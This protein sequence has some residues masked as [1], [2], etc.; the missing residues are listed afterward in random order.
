MKQIFTCICFLLVTVGY[1]QKVDKTKSSDVFSFATFE[2]DGRDSVIKCQVIERY[3]KLSMYINNLVLNEIRDHEVKYSTRIAISKLLESSESSGEKFGFEDYS[4]EGKSNMYYTNENYIDKLIELKNTL[5]AY[6]KKFLANNCFKLEGTPPN[7]LIDSIY[8]TPVAKGKFNFLESTKKSYR[9]TS[10]VRSQDS[11]IIAFS[12]IDA[13]KTIRVRIMKTLKSNIDYKEYIVDYK[14]T[15]EQ[16]KKIR[17]KEDSITLD[18]IKTLKTKLTEL[19]QEFATYEIRFIHIS[20]DLIPSLKD[21]IKDYR[22]QQNDCTCTEVVLEDNDGDGYDSYV[23]CDDNNPNVNPGARINCDNGIDDDNCDGVKDLCC[24]DKDGDGYYRKE[25][26]DCITYSEALVST[27]EA[28]LCDCNDDDPTVHPHALINCN[29][30]YF[31]DNCDGVRDTIYKG[32]EVYLTFIDNVY[33][34]Y[35]ITAFGKDKPFYIYSGL[36]LGGI[37]TTAYFKIRSNKFYNRH[38]NSETF[39]GAKTNYKEANDLHHA[40]IISAA[41]TGAVYLTSLVDLKIRYAKYNKIRD[42]ILNKNKSCVYNYD[43]LLDPLCINSSGFGPS[44]TLKF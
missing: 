38:L 14:K 21:K 44:L 2:F 25:D 7:V 23:D 17:Y 26:C 4:L 22:N 5:D 20:E 42:G 8:Y 28:N 43:L 39:R 12:K 34:P 10:N 13:E 36:I 16:Y 33:P 3:K 6:E 35:G 40:F 18:S 15:Y 41:A 1:S 11:T 31:D 37:A 27:T 30:S 24:V 29:N 9:A 19:E 32:S